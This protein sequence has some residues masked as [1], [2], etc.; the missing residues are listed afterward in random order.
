MMKTHLGYNILMF[1]FDS[2]S[3]MTFMRLLPK[4]YSFLIKE[5]G[6]VVMKGEF[7]TKTYSS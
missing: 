1:G 6:A 3:R 4:T 5:L 7:S 2:V